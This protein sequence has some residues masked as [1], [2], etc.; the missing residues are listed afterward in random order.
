M[1]IASTNGKRQGSGGFLKKRTKKLRHI[2]AEPTRK[3]SEADFSESFCF[4]FSKK[5]AFLLLALP[6]PAYLG[7]YLFSKENGFL[8][9][10]FT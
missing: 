8:P 1:E 5:Q 6:A 9:L 7:S 3:G 4:F 10:A 2:Q